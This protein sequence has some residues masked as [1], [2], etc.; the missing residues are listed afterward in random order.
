[1]SAPYESTRVKLMSLVKTFHDTNYPTMDVNYPDKFT[2]DIEKIE[3]PFTTVELSMKPR[4][5]GL[6]AG[7]C[8]QIS[9]QLILNHYARINTGAKIHTVYTDLLITYLGWKTID[10]ITFREVTPFSNTGIPG[11][12]G[13]MN[14]VNFEIEYFNI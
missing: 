4:N 14:V 2:T 13:I 9:G 11:F 10:Q 3:V 6:K 7:H 1:M 12:K 5:M 8:V